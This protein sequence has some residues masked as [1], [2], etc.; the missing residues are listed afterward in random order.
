M[1]V[2]AKLENVMHDRALCITHYHYP[3]PGANKCIKSLMWIVLK[4][5][6]QKY[7]D[8]Q[9]AVGPSNRNQIKLQENQ[10]IGRAQIV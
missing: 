10:T 8:F 2:S 6:H 3:R 7:L 4:E 9:F 5:K 1:K